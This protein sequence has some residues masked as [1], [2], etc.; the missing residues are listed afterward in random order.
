MKLKIS[1]RKD[2]TFLQRFNENALWWGIPMVGLE[3]ISVPLWG[4]LTVLVIAIPA[5]LAGILVETGIEYLL[6][7]TLA[8]RNEIEKH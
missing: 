1:V 4:W 5:T 6:I 2:R 7:R 8:R 3:L